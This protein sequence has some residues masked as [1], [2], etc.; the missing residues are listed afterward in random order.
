MLNLGTSL[1]GDPQGHERFDA[2]GGRAGGDGDDELAGSQA[3]QRQIEAEARARYATNNTAV[4]AL[5]ARG[6]ADVAE[7][8]PG[9]AA[10]FRKELGLPEK[11]APE[12]MA[13]PQADATKPPE[14]RQRDMTVAEILEKERR[15]AAQRTLKA[16]RQRM[17]KV[18]P[19]DKDW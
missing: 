3:G 18:R 7:L 5:C 9:E 11:P 1:P 14:R 8:E 13:E 10:E 4:I 15:E 17:G 16:I 19:A 6:E 12:N 2:V